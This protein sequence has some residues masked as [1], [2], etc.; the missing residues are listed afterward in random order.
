MPSAI[1]A[2]DWVSQPPTTWA[3]ARKKFVTAPTTVTRRM[4]R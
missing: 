1:S 3:S 4:E 2:C